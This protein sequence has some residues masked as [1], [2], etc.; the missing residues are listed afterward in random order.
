[1]SEQTQEPQSNK[2][3]LAIALLYEKIRQEMNEEP[4]DKTITIK[5]GKITM[6]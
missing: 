4:S 2:L 5:K 3:Q 1:M 6:K